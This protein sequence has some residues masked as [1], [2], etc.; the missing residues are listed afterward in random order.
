M[1]EGKAGLLE[2][3]SFT[4]AIPEG[5]WKRKGGGTGKNQEN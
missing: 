1:K 4:L 5:N 2:G 3:E